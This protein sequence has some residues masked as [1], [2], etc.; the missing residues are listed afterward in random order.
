[1]AKKTIQS[2]VW[3]NKTAIHLA[4]FAFVPGTLSCS[5][6][7]SRLNLHLIGTSPDTD[8]VTVTFSI[9][10]TP[11]RRSPYTFQKNTAYFGIDL[12]DPGSSASA[13]IAVET[14]AASCLIGSGQTQVSISSGQTYE[15]DITVNTTPKA[16][17]LVIKKTGDGNVQSDHSE[18]DC[19]QA[20]TA[21]FPIGTKVTL[22]AVPS[23]TG[24][25]YQW[26][27]KCTGSNST[28]TV[29]IDSAVTA[30][31]DFTPRICT[32]AGF[33]WEYPRPLGAD[34]YGAWV[35]PDQTLHAVGAY[36]TFVRGNGVTWST[37]NTGT[38]QSLF[39]VWGSSDTDIWAVGGTAGSA[40]AIIHYDGQSAKVVISPTIQKL[41][42]VWGSANNNIY[43]VGDGGAI[44]HYDGT[45]WT[46]T[47][48]GVENLL[49]VWGSGPGDLWASGNN[50]TLLRNQGSGWMP[51]SDNVP[52]SHFVPNVD[53]RSIWGTGPG[54]VW[55]AGSRLVRWNGTAWNLTEYGLGIP[56]VCQ[57][58][59]GT[60]A[61]TVWC[62]GFGNIYR[63]DGSQW[64]LSA[65]LDLNSN[66]LVVAGAGK[67][68]WAVGRSGV[69]ASLTNDTWQLNS[70]PSQQTFNSI[71]MNDATNGW[72]I[73][74]GG[75]AV[76]TQDGLTWTSQNLNTK[77]DLTAI[78]AS[79]TD[80]VWV[81]GSSGTILRYNGKWSIVSPPNGVDITS[82]RLTSIFGT[83]PND[84]WIVGSPTTGTGSIAL[85]WDG[86]SLGSVPTPPDGASSVVVYQGTPYIADG[87]ATG[88]YQ[89][90][91]M[92]WNQ[93]K[94]VKASQLAVQGNAL[95]A[96]GTD[97]IYRYDGSNWTADVAGEAFSAVYARSPSDAWA[98]GGT[99]PNMRLLRWNGT[100]WTEVE[101]F[102]QPIN[103][104]GGFGPGDTW[105]V[106]GGGAVLHLKQ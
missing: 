83:G 27:G 34:L 96:V 14:Y 3:C 63:W 97:G 104:I 44:L 7:P 75:S 79:G 74:I 66:S 36:G 8:S 45:N 29:T 38:P 1:M 87:N 50:H 62:G 58:I 24:S 18:L 5:S 9:N 103:G 81:V 48:S 80:N 20:C 41:N 30:S 92:A 26:G 53:Y 68:A 15:G 59:W 17:P 22:S 76:Q 72:A 89:L 54:D 31:I 40:S 42:A 64:S 37:I 94:G 21:K 28:C 57:S 13:K 49:S 16:C 106:G 55:A 19:G 101:R 78:W 70:S 51:L 85:H 105:V 84:I 23:V 35:A 52:N 60:G 82:G 95:F 69:I 2:L 32:P 65:A 56:G 43:A 10:G 33:C 77:A 88:I 39:G 4:L 11:D 100:T 86:T 12:P 47:S 91:G 71:W 46:A 102:P 61:N 25:R 90:T 99:Y 93:V 6:G 73:G 67:A 98:W